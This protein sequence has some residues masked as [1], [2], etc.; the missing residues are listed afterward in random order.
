MRDF[1]TPILGMLN[2]SKRA[3]DEQRNQCFNQLKKYTTAKT[4]NKFLADLNNKND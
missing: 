2:K 1:F 3:R 4:N